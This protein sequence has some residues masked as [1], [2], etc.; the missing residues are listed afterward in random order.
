[1]EEILIINA[2][3]FGSSGPF[4]YKIEFGESINGEEKIFGKINFH[5]PQVLIGTSV[6]I[7]LLGQKK[8]KSLKKLINKHIVDKE[9]MSP[10]EINGVRYAAN[11][12]E[13]I[14]LLHFDKRRENDSIYNGDNSKKGK[15]KYKKLSNDSG[16]EW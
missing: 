12:I 9:V 15:T 5:H 16:E 4:E 14:Y 10:I 1:M 3:R 8:N 6:F 2:E 11:Y 13:Q 7:K